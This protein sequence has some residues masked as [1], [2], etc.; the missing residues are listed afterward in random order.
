MKTTVEKYFFDQYHHQPTVIVRSPGRVNI[1]GEHAD[2]N[3][4]FVLPAAIDKAAY[5]AVSLRDDQEIHL[6]ALDLNEKFST[7]VDELK[8]IGDVSWPNY[9]LGSAAQFLKHG[10]QLPGFNAVLTSNVPIGAGLSSSAA[11]ECATVF[12]LNHLLKT[13]IERVAMVAMA[14]K[15][16]HEYAGV[17]CGIMDQ[18]ASMMGKANQ[19]IKLDCRSLEYEYVPFKLDGIKILLLN[20]NVKHSL[21]S[22]EYNTRRLECMQAVEMIQAYHPEVQSL[23]DATVEMLDQYVLPFNDLVYQRS[24]F[25][26]DEMERLNQACQ[27]LQDDNLP[28]LGNCM[29]KTHDGLSRQYEVSCKELDYLVDFVRSR[30]EVIGARMMGGGFG[31]CTINLVQEDKIESLINSIKPAYEEAMGLPLDY[32]I[33]TIQNGTEII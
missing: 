1:V 28:A 20:T 2:Y 8:P 15:A 29:F 27:F 17:M 33:A 12:A 4:G 13:N 24:R 31:G 11:V 14:Q 25:V 30:K 22:S 19:V 9:I 18:F 3:N 16:E 7:T 26:V 6:I 10:I 32:Y 21:A 5:L 23:R